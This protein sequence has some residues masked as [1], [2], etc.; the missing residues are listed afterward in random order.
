MITQPLLLIRQSHA[1]GGNCLVELGLLSHD[2]VISDS[3]TS[4]LINARDAISVK[5]ILSD[6]CSLLLM[7]IYKQLAMEVSLLADLPSSEQA[8]L[9][10]QGAT[11]L[12][13]DDETLVGDALVLAACSG[14]PD[15][16]LLRECGPVG[17]TCLLYS[18]KPLELSDL[19]ELEQFDQAEARWLKVENLESFIESPKVLGGLHTRNSDSPL[20]IRMIFKNME[21]CSELMHNLASEWRGIHIA[22]MPTWHWR[23]G[24]RSLHFTNI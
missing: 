16:N 12:L 9:R 22:E 19:P 13:V 14:L 8:R 24:K 2:G 18:V 11:F 23:D 3:S 10:D 6:W 20:G 17:A 7:Q 15:L 4:I 5:N 1:R 21:T